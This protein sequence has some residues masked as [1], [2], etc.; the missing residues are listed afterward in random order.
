MSS[1]KDSQG[2]AAERPRADYGRAVHE[3]MTAVISES[4]LT[5]EQIA[6]RSEH[7]NVHELRAAL[8]GG[9]RWWFTLTLGIAD[10][11]GVDFLEYIERI[12]AHAD[13]QR[14]EKAKR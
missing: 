7:V 13:R 10:A 5:P 1:I 9:D 11:I 14:S 2:L 3:T 8:A 4:G 12:E 6:E